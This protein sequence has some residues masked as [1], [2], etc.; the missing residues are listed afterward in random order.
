MSSFAKSD[1]SAPAGLFAAE[2]AGLRWLAEPGVIP[3]VDVFSE[4]PTGLELERIYSGRPTPEDAREFGRRLARLHDAGAPG[5]GYSPYPQSAWFGPLHRPIPVPTSARPDFAT[6]WASD[7]LSPMLERAEDTL[8]EAGMQAVEDAIDVIASGAFDG[9]CGRGIE[10]PARVHGDLW[11]GNVMWART[12]GVTGGGTE[13]T[14]IDPAA[15]GGHR[16]ED[17]ALLS[18]FGAPHLGDIYAGY[19]EAHPLPDGWR[20][21]LPAHLL[22]ALLAHV[23]LFGGTY[24]QPTE[25]AALEVVA[26]ARELGAL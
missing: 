10:E 13:G 3:V 5:F 23:Y 1:P 9:I 20:Q 24:S 2:A 11:T 14:L 21:D 17:L 8:P 26:R 19:A 25:S 7:R 15:H 16:L 18:L 22:F 12:S 6:Y 4:S